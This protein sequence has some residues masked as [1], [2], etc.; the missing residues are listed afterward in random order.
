VHVFDRFEPRGEDLVLLGDL[1]LGGQ[2]CVS[3]VRACT[4]AQRKKNGRRRKGSVSRHASDAPYA[5]G[6]LIEAAGSQTVRQAGTLHTTAP[7]AAVDR[8]RTGSRS[9][10]EAP[11]YG[12]F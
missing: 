5:F 6:R 4:D 10:P 3:E 9:R 12:P 11:T 8:G 2:R 7:S 1:I